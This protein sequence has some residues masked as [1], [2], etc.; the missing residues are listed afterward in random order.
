M[1][2]HMAFLCFSVGMPKGGVYEVMWYALL[3][4]PF[5][6]VLGLEV[7]LLVAVIYTIF[8]GVAN[9]EAQPG[10]RDL[11]FKVRFAK[12][13]AS[14]SI[15]VKRN[16]D[17]KSEKPF[18]LRLLPLGRVFDEIWTAR[19]WALSPPQLDHTRVSFRC[20]CGSAVWTDYPPEHAEG[21]AR[22]QGE[23][24]TFYAA[25]QAHTGASSGKSFI[26]KI[27]GL[28][29]GIPF[30][31]GVFKN[32]FARNPRG[33]SPDSEA[34]PRQSQK[35][36]TQST[37]DYY[38]TCCRQVGDRIPWLF[39]LPSRDINCDAAYFEKLRVLSR[40]LQRRWERWLVPRKIVEIRYVQVSGSS[41]QLFHA[42][43]S[44]K[45]TYLTPNSSSLC[46][47]K[48]MSTS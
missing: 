40:N 45:L 39:Q 10:H 34:Q 42:M 22:L 26:N 36:G 43:V 1:M 21:A 7:P 30:V 27:G 38:L 5:M 20:A 32:Y 14:V 47:T 13:P 8:V 24:R 15:Y 48:S 31:L 37:T 29:R 9:L 33:R 46:S 3:L 4:Y 2:M 16:V 44:N 18:K 19:R 23:L 41:E 35:A 11:K 12:A 28:F 17:C 25:V 6:L